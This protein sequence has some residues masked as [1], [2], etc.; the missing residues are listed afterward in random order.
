MARSGANGHQLSGTDAGSRS[1]AMNAMSKLVG[2]DQ[3]FVLLERV[4][5]V[6]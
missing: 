6:C 1:F 4:G 5:V 2:L 3:L